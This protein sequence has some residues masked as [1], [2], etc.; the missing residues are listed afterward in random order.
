MGMCRSAWY[1][2]EICKGK[3]WGPDGGCWRRVWVVIYDKPGFPNPGFRNLRFTDA[4]TH[5]HTHTHRYILLANPDKQCV[6][7]NG[8]LLHYQ[9]GGRGG[10]SNRSA[11]V[12]LCN[13]SFP[14]CGRPSRLLNCPLLRKAVDMSSLKLLKD[15]EGYFHFSSL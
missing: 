3:F 11:T 14:Q 1:H 13:M 2:G 15:S 5:T 9:V 6:V 8:P 10:R 4:N 7:A 12:L